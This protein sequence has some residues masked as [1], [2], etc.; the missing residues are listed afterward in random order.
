MQGGD[1]HAGHAYTSGSNMAAHKVTCPKCGISWAVTGY[2]HS[3]QCPECDHIFYPFEMSDQWRTK[4]LEI[5]PDI[6][7]PLVLS[8]WTQNAEVSLKGLVDRIKAILI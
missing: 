8:R 3:F 2:N 1:S 7:D 6:E 5:L 4:I